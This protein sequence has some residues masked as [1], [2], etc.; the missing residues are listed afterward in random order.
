MSKRDQEQTSQLWIDFHEE[1]R[2]FVL[3]KTNKVDDTEDILQNAFL[4][5]AQQSEKIRQAKE[6]KPYIY[7]IVRNSIYDFY[8]AEKKRKPDNEIN[9]N[10]NENEENQLNNLIDDNCIAPLIGLLPDIYRDALYQTVYNNKSQI[11]FAK[12][13]GISH[14]AVK[15]RVQRGRLLLKELLITYCIQKSDRYGE[16]NSCEKTCDC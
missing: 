15:S 6:I 8:R 9:F 1:L 12:D 13:L 16:I 5:M 3:M 11:E 4:R 7:A 10:L 2:A 14:S